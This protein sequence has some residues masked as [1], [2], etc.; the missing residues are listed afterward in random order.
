[1]VDNTVVFDNS[2]GAD[3]PIHLI[4]NFPLNDG[5]YIYPSSYV[6]GNDGIWSAIELVNDLRVRQSFKNFI[7]KK[8]GI[9]ENKIKNQIFDGYLRVIEE[10]LNNIYV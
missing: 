2:L 8:Y 7:T 3:D 4:F 10:K 1:M 9:I 5:G 6:F